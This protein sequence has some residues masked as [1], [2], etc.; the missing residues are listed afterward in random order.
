MEQIA[1]AWQCLLHAFRQL[2]R[3]ALWGPWLVLGATQAVVVGALAWFAHPA[4]SSLVAPF[5]LDAGGER[6][7]HYP[8]LFRALPLLFARID[9][10]I[11]ATLGALAVGASTALFAAGHGSRGPRAAAAWGTALRRVIPLVLV[12]LP[13][14]LIGLGLAIGSDALAPDSGITRR[15]VWAASLGL[16][17]LVQAWFLY[18]TAF[19]VLEGRGPLS[20]LAELHRS[21]RRGMAAALFLTI[22]TAAPLLPVQELAQARAAVVGHGAPEIVGWLL[23]AQIGAALVSSFLLTGSATLVFQSAIAGRSDS[24]W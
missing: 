13:L 3:P 18:A 20:T 9:R 17:I 6:A 5:V 23:L 12:H 24:P 2:L 19:V 4:L 16:T 11:G 22:V 1:L 8:A 10:V 21:A 15:I 7:M 14:T